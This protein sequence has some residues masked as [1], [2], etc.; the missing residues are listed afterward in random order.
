MPPEVL[1][2]RALNRALLSRQLLLE[3]APL[4]A[5]VAIER[6]VGMQA[7]VATSPYAGLWSR[8]E[9][10]RHEELAGLI[11][12][13]A[14]VRTSLMRTTLPLVTAADALAL[15]RGCHPGSPY[16]RLVAG[17]D[18][19]AVL[20]AGTAMLEERPLTVAELGRRLA[21]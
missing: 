14:A 10:F 12:S 11:T 1:G 5:A 9:D 6:L 16:G 15:P 20:A 7:Q 13:R 21:E 8:L 18:I 3:R 2:R 4:P 17:A 19:D